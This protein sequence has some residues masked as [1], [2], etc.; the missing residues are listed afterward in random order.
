MRRG[1]YIIILIVLWSCQTKV[2]SPE[3][4]ATWVNTHLR[5]Q[6]SKGQLDYELHYQPI[7]YQA[8]KELGTSQFEATTFEQALADFKGH[9][10]MN[11]KVQSP[12]GKAIAVDNALRFHA[13]ED[14]KA[15][16]NQDTL[17]CVLYHL[18]Q[19]QDQIQVA[20]V[21]QAKMDEQTLQSIELQCENPILCPEGLRI[22]IA[23]KYIQ[24]IPSLKR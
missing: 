17:P 14:F 24:K 21:F 23:E 11:L 6:I 5:Q 8:L 4:Y 20:L 22:S 9:H 15:L 13:R 3:Q 16:I 1:S 7:A 12:I 18:N 19:I 2:A 10:Y